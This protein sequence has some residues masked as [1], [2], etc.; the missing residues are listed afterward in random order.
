MCGV[1]CVARITN[2]IAA[3]IS[4][5]KVITASLTTFYGNVASK[6]NGRRRDCHLTGVGTSDSLE[7]QI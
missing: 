1:D 7:G 4:R 6:L 5:K 3:E 2:Q